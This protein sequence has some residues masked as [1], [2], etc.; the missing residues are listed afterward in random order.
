M[1]PPSFTIGIEEEYLLVDR[2]TRNLVADPHPDLWEDAHRRLGSAVMPELLKA[3]IE[4]A[5][6]PHSDTSALRDDLKAM[7]SEVSNA[8]SKFD[9]AIIASSTHPFALWWEQQHTDK[10]RYLLLA[11]DLAVV[12]QRLVICGMHVHVAIEDPDLRIDLMNQVTYFLPHLLALSTSS[13]FWGS[14]NTGLKSYR[15]NVFRTLPRT[16]FPEHFESWAEYQRHVDVLVNAGLIE[17]SSKLWW[18]VRPSARYPTLEMRVCDICTRWEDAIAIA[19]LYRCLLHMLYRLRRDN[20]RWR[21]YANMLVSENLWRAQRYGVEASLMDFGE[22]TLVPFADLAD[23][24]AFLVQPDA[25]ILGC[26]DEIDHIRTIARDGTSARRQ[27]ETYTA[28][29]ASGAGE[30]EALQAVVDELIRDTTLG[31]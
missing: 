4:I 11:Q 7:R 20:Q 23:E 5:T 28:A 18:D 9:A 27:V 13:P 29:L 22:S 24:M 19:S 25:E 31:L 12:G 16:G 8:A 26:V 15:M 3:Q 6:R 10:D 17:D 2:Q 1:T 30:S 21:T 14:R